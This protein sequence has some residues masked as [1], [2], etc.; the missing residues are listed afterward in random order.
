MFQKLKI[1]DETSQYIIINKRAGLIAE[2]NPFE[3]ITAESLV[4]EYLRTGKRT[5]FSLD[6]LNTPL[7]K[8]REDRPKEPATKLGKGKIKTKREAKAAKG[9]FVGVV[10]RLDRVTSGVMVFAK[11]QSC[12]KKLNDD[13]SK[14]KIKKTY[15]A[16]VDNMPPKKAGVLRHNLV[17]L[18][19]EKMAKIHDTKQDNSVECTLTYKLLASSSSGHLLKIDLQTGRFH[20]IRAQL[21]HIGCPIIGD[22]KYGSTKKH[23]PLAICLHAWKINLKDVSTA[24]S[25]E[26]IAEMPNTRFWKDFDLKK[27][28]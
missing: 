21:A 8:H 9:T 10:H 24:E 2:R 25:K 28:E 3:T 26:Y 16:I 17:K 20:Q 6:K 22:E 4:E 7:E 18:Q 12:L 5:P 15:L 14:N 1:V 13:L 27:I 11:N 23:L 19:K